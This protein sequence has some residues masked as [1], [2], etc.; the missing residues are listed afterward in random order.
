MPDA[1]VVVTAEKIVSI[2]RQ[3]SRVDIQEHIVTE[4]GTGLKEVGT[5]NQSKRA[6]VFTRLFRE[7]ASLTTSRRGMNVVSDARKGIEEIPLCLRPATKRPLF[8]AF[9]GPEHP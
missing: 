9:R 7:A 2:A 3:K 8:M 4:V 1:N 6:E 5:P